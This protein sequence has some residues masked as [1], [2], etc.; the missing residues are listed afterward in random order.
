MEVG[1]GVA[2]EVADRITAA[3]LLEEPVDEAHAGPP[4]SR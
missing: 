4:L 1:A 3:D 2:G